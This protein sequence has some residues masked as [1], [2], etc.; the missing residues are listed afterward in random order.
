MHILALKG[1]VKG[2][3][4]LFDIGGDINLQDKDGYSPLWFAIQENQINV[5]K[6]LLRANCRLNP[7]PECGSD[8][9]WHC[10][11][12]AALNK[13]RFHLAKML[14]VAGCDITALLEWLENNPL[15]SVED[16]NQEAVE[17]LDQMTH[18][19]R[20]LRQMCRMLIRKI[21]GDDLQRKSMQLP[22]P[23][24]LQD[25]ITLKELEQLHD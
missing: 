19:P 6:F 21:L 11:L 25:Y 10:P 8:T 13:Q 16:E 15:Y 3:E 18:V 20:V 2:M 17:F 14:I 12:E 9:P 5:V 23:P 7:P 24:S 1:H 22:I 4:H